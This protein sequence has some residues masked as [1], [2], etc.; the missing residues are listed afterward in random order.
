MYRCD[1]IELSLFIQQK[2]TRLLVSVLRQNAV[3]FGFLS[4]D[5]TYKITCYAGQIIS[6]STCDTNHICCLCDAHVEQND[7][8]IY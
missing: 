8:I 2:E 7:V 5:E 6:S 3:L 1:K 4:L